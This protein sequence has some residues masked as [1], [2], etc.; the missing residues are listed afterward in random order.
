MYILSPLYSCFPCILWHSYEI[1]LFFLSSVDD[2]VVMYYYD[3]LLSCNFKG[4]EKKL[5]PNQMSSHIKVSFHITFSF[6]KFPYI[7]LCVCYVCMGWVVGGW[8]YVPKNNTFSPFLSFYTK[9]KPY[10]CFCVVCIRT[11]FDMHADETKGHFNLN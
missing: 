2:V 5:C 3:I 4:Q 7:V 10:P 6:S 1:L 11:M 8:L 9:Q